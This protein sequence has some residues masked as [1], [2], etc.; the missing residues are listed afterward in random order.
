M[1]I[2]TLTGLR[3]PVAVLALCVGARTAR[4]QVVFDTHT[5]ANLNSPRSGDN[6]SI[7]GAGQ[8]IS[9]ATNTTMTRFG[10]TGAATAGTFEFFVMDATDATVL[11][12]QMVTYTANQN[13]F[14]ES[15]PFSFNLVAGQSYFLGLVLAPHAGMNFFY[16]NPRLTFTQN[17]ISLAGGATNYTNY[18]SPTWVS[19][20]TTV[21][22]A[23]RI[24]GTQGTSAPVTTA[25]EP[26]SV[27]LLGTGLAAL[28]G[29]A[30]RRV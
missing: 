13:G 26:A 5:T 21:S 7:S 15:D 17:G 27:V 24:E 19:T 16:N 3:V 23:M 22:L 30:R 2:L 6:A 14:V 18:G 1:R 28:F 12:S 20:A 29:V 8:G 25:P 10:F 9:V 4:A 11:F